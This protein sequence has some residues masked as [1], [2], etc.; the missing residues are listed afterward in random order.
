MV[1]DIRFAFPPPQFKNKDSPHLRSFVFV[2]LATDE[3][4][5]PSDA[6]LAR[7]HRAAFASKFSGN[8]VINKGQDD[9]SYSTEL[10]IGSSF[11][12]VGISVT[13][14][15]C[16]FL[17]RQPKPATEKSGTVVGELRV[18]RRLIHIIHTIRYRRASAI[19]ID[20]FQKMLHPR[21]QFGE[22]RA[23]PTPQC[24]SPF[25]STGVAVGTSSHH[26]QLLNT[27][28]GPRT[29]EK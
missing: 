24:H 15:L 5:S 12:R 20:I 13:L 17:N 19:G 18:T 3:D 25:G 28:D 29:Q 6:R 16:S 10:S 9:I 2:P 26:P 7:A 14:L 11:C 21:S 4:S 22:H 8:P 23:L 27:R 1:D